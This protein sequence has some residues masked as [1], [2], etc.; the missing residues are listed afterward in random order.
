MDVDEAGRDDQTADVD[1]V[2]RF[3]A[4][5][6]AQRHDAAILDANVRAARRRARAVDERSATQG[7]VEHALTAAARCGA[8][9]LLLD[10]P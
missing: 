3:Q 10:P 1:G 9:R 8:P 4:I 7:D 6:R 2:H 5:Q